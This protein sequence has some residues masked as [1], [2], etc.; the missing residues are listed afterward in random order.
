MTRC[1]ESCNLF[2]PLAVGDFQV[3]ARLSGLLEQ[4]SSL[5][6][7]ADA[8]VSLGGEVTNVHVKRCSSNI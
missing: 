8:V 1:S 5:Y 6:N 3:V 2:I 4:R 7:N